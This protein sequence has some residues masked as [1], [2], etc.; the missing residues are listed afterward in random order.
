[1][2]NDILRLLVCLFIIILAA[3]A[4]AMGDEKYIPYAATPDEISVADLR[5]QVTYD[6][7][8]ELPNDKEFREQLLAAVELAEK[9]ENRVRYMVAQ[10]MVPTTCWNKMLLG[11]VIV[12]AQ[13]ANY[14]FIFKSSSMNIQQVDKM[15]YEDKVYGKRILDQGY[16][17]SF[18]DKKDC[19]RSFSYAYDSIKTSL[20][21]YECNRL[22]SYSLVSGQ[23]H[24]CARWNRSGKILDE[25]VKEGKKS[26]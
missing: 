12:E 24:F 6:R 21:F 11:S 10:G 8:F 5:N 9:E 3:G 15:V 4:S 20:N 19:I 14:R 26:K 1:M 18:Y 2:R 16:S 13:K 22:E 23:R 25:G 7:N 17:I